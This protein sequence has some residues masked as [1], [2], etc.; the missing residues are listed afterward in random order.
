MT[1]KTHAALHAAPRA[2]RRAARCHLSEIG[3]EFCC[4]LKTHVIAADGSHH[5]QTARL[6]RK[7][8]QPLME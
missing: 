4:T 8:N 7:C 6:K 2:A 3:C 5:I 1:W